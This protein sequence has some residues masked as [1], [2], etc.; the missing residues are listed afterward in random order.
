M[1]Y[2]NLP[3]DIIDTVFDFLETEESIWVHH[4][5]DNNLL[6]KVNKNSST[7][8]KIKNTLIKKIYK[9][10]KENIIQIMD[11]D[12]IIKT[13][14]VYTNYIEFTNDIL[15]T[16]VIDYYLYEYSYYF[17]PVI[18][19][20][21]IVYEK[22]YVIIIKNNNDWNHHANIEYPY[23]YGA[24]INGFHYY[25]QEHGIEK[26]NLD[27]E[28]IGYCSSYRTFPTINGAQLYEFS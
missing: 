11:E 21:K 28:Y 13:L 12:G 16:D 7:I 4:Y 27:E 23:G 2:K 15:Q 18:K 17:K 24:V 25:N 1:L 26:R 19:N 8:Q 6:M 3:R 22:N 10:T 14:N 20:N 9:P 5:K